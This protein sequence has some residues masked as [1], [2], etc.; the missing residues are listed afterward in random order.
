M[1]ESIPHM[2][3]PW[4]DGSG[5]DYSSPYR[6]LATAIVQLAVKDYKKTL[7]ATGL[8]LNRVWITPN[9]WTV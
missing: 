2:K 8:Y 1:K 7:R 6:D 4:D 3:P 5:P 9:W